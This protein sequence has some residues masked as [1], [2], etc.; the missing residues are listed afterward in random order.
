MSSLNSPTFLFCLHIYSPCS[1]SKNRAKLAFIAP[2]YMALGCWFAVCASW[3]SSKVKRE[4]KNNVSRRKRKEKV[5]LVVLYC[6]L[7]VDLIVLATFSL[8][9]SEEPLCCMSYMTR[10]LPPPPPSSKSGLI[11]SRVWQAVHPQ[12]RTR[13][14]QNFINS[15]IVLFTKVLYSLYFLSESPLKRSFHLHCAKLANAP[16]I[17]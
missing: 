16:C 3:S 1:K 12:L 17:I 11:P 7:L 8:V 14:V 10:V 13:V 5:H 9:Q 4:M 15:D 6:L 2:F